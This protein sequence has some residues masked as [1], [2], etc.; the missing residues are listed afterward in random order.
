MDYAAYL[1][2]SII[3]VWFLIG[4]LKKAVPKLAGEYSRF[5][6]VI[7]L[8]LGI[9]VAGYGSYLFSMSMV[10]VF[11]TGIIPALASSGVHSYTNEIKNAL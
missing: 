4:V 3:A 11:I 8:A 10:E 9:A 6:P 5:I 7:A 1:G 2:A